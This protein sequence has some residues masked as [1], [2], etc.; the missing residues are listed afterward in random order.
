MSND[1][2]VRRFLERMAGEIEVSPLDG[3]AP[4]KRAR[5]YRSVAVA[6]SV[7]VVA[8]ILVAG[9]VG[10]RSITRTAPNPVEEPTVSPIAPSDRPVFQRVATIGGLTIT[11]PSTWYLVDYWGDWNPDATSL[12]S[13]A[14]PLLELTNFDPGLSTP[15]CDTRSGEPTRLPADGVAIFVLV[16]NDG[17]TAAD[18]CGGS[19]DTSSTGTTGPDP[20]GRAGPVPYISAMTFGPG[21][22]DGDRATAQQ[23]WRSMA[24]GGQL[25]FYSR[26]RTPRYVLD[27]WRNGSTTDLFE[28]SGSATNVDLSTIEIGPSGQGGD[29][30]A[31]SG[32]PGASAVEGDTFGAVTK[33]A[34]RVEYLRAGV[35][36]PL[37]AKLIDLPPSFHPA[38]DA[39]V[40]EPQPSGGPSEVD[41]IGADGKL[42]GSNLPPLVHTV[43]VGTVNAFGTTWTVKL[44]SDADG[45]SPST[46]IEPAETSTLR[47]CDRPPG[48]G[49]PYLQSSTGQPASVFVTQ[50]VGNTV[51]GV[52]LQADGGTVFHAV[53]VPISPGDYTAGNVAV[54]ALEGGGRGRFVYHLSGGGTDE[55]R[56]PEAHVSWPDLG[57][58][59]GNGSF[60]PPGTA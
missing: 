28:A 52:D 12:D 37:V 22:T 49:G 41:A 38:F 3:H 17:R 29:D 42:L 32:V 36:T 30:V 46:C 21:V 11:S 35:D 20:T 16:G 48:G 44:S 4:A 60:P 26:G 59:I 56:R 25:T 8:A 27:S 51:Q 6:V 40:F 15:V 10:L 45:N 19:I 31:V 58:V 5:R 7:V 2:N 24:W 23:V 50:A 1:T 54:V 47:P 55:G 9:S 14:I 33:A 18:L 34:A 39:Y 43:R 13:H 57:Q 53:M